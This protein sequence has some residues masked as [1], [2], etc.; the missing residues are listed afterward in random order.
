MPKK[1]FFLLTLLLF[2]IQF[3]GQQASLV[4]KIIDSLGND[5]ATVDCSYPLTGSCLKLQVKDIPTVYETTSYAMSSVPYV[6][7]VPYTSGTKLNADADDTFINKLTIPFGFCY[8]GNVY[9]EVVVGSNGMLA[10]N[11]AQVGNQNYPNVM[12]PNPSI[13]LPHNSIFGVYS[14]LFFSK[15]DESEIYYQVVGTAPS[16]KFIVS[17]YKAT[18]VGCEVT[19]TTQIVLHEGSNII[20]IFVEDKPAPCDGAKF[21]NSLLGIS[22]SDGTVGY[23]PEERNTGVW[24]AKKEGWR[25]TPAGGEV[26]PMLTWYNSAKQLV[27]T[28]QKVTVCPTKSDVYTVKIEY[29]VCGS[30][31]NILQDDFPVTYA[32]DFPVLNNY[33]FVYCSG[34]SPTVN[35]NDFTKNLTTQDP[36]NFNFTF[37]ATLQDAKDGVNPIPTDYTVNNTP[38]YVRAENKTDAGCFQTAVLNLSTIGASLLTNT[39]NV[40]DINNNGVENNY[41]LTILDNQLFNLPIQGTIRYF[42]TAADATANTNEVKIANLKEG[43]Q[44]Y[45]RYETSSCF[46]VF[47]PVSVHFV[48]SPD[49]PAEVN[50]PAFTVCDE[51]RD[52]SEPFNFPANV[53]PLLNADPRA[54]LSYYEDS[55]DAYAGVPSKLKTIH[56]GQYPVYVRVQIPGDI[57]FSVAT[58][59]FDIKF[60]KVESVNI[61]KKICF[62]GTPTEMSVD[63]ALSAISMLK[64]SP[65]GITNGYFATLQDAIE[66]KNPISPQQTVVINGSFV[67]K[68]FYVRF[69]DQTGCFAVKKLELNLIRITVNANPVVCDFYQDGQEN[70]LLSTLNGQVVGGQDVTLTYFASRA[71]ADANTNPITSAVIKTGN[72]KLFIR[73]VSSCAMEVK[74]INVK[75]VS[76]PVV[77]PTYAPDFG[78]VCDNNNDGVELFNISQ[79]QSK[80][81]TGTEKVTYNYYTGYNPANNT[82]TGLISNPTAFPAKGDVTVYVKVTGP[83]GCFSVSTL[84]IKINFKPTIVLT[85]KATLEKCDFELDANETFDL[86][87]GIPLL[88]SPEKNTYT[89]DDL[90]VTYYKT[91]ADAEKGQRKISSTFKTSANGITTLWAR[92]TSSS[93]SCYS[94]AQLDLFTAYPPKARDAQITGL[95]DNN[96]DGLYEVDLTAYTDRMIFGTAVKDYTFTFFRTQSEAQ[97]F[98]STPIANPSNFTFPST[99]T[100]LWVRVENVPGC[101]DIA[102]IDLKYGTKVPIN[103]GPFNLNPCDAGNNKTETVDLTQLQTKIYG[104]QATFEYYESNEDLANGK[105]IA[106]PSSYIYTATAAPKKVIVKVLAPGFCAE[107]TEINLSLRPSPVFSVADQ[108]FCLQEPANFRPN[109]SGLNITKF[110]WLDP[111]GKVVSTTDKLLNVVVAGRYK[112]NVTAAN[113]CTFSTEFNAIPYIVPVIK[114][115]TLNGNIFTVTAIGDRPMLYSSD[116]VNFQSSNLFNADNLP[117]GVTQFFVRY[118]DSACF[119]DA[120]NGLKLHNTFT[121][122]ADGI[123]DTWVI[124]QLDLFNG[125]KLNLKVFNRYQEKIFEQ[126]SATRLEWDG[127]NLSRVVATDSYW[128]VLTLPDGTIYT[129]WVLL[130]NRN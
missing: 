21:K 36:S 39:V 129:G 117:F 54:V 56:E 40:C 100:R 92:F 23:S 37:Y 66:N 98:L 84:N 77:V 99:L 2:N 102:F 96:F 112:I 58:V 114:S 50:Y 104:S 41:D 64:Q 90:V 17:F 65:I 61:T 85:Q 111:S 32:V 109:F 70:I 126:E 119:S 15:N 67:T 11:T 30:A 33:S 13:T 6:P 113:G 88:F 42:L 107:K 62:T 28:G 72:N 105:Q 35:L 16:R 7:A 91:R 4:P 103:K 29:P 95:C 68:A 101:F 48:R 51:L 27:G 53:G 120:K 128:Y 89:I 20:E 125:E 115:V 124:D 38:V 78:T 86:T 44:L 18:I 45:I 71:D 52:Y 12:S 74:E 60:N 83:G 34:S 5:K 31:A 3:Y 9:N 79:F 63:L 57:C 123:N 55:R 97:S 108:Y 49:V 76:T 94:V 24:G 73:M 122:N 81:Y 130:K 43:T 19:S 26:V 87:A 8:F 127:K 69:T 25:F 10:F 75:L 22:N 121:P 118:A 80:I 59:N 14:D 110:E 46:H 116:G 106:T 82:L 47:D 1:V 93:Q